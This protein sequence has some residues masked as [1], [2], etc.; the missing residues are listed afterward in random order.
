M[1]LD[2]NTER[3]FKRRIALLALLHKGPCCYDDIIAALDREHLLSY[4]AEEDHKKIKNQQKY[5]FRNDRRA[6]KV[7]G[8]SIPFDRKSKCYK[9][10][11]SPFGLSFDIPQLNTLSILR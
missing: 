4:D 11:N 1:N 10:L 7:L 3:A 8:Y 9:W 6:L 5:Q 2:T